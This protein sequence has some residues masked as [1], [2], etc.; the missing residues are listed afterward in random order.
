MSKGGLGATSP[1]VI[2]SNTIADMN[3]SLRDIY[4]EENDIGPLF[5]FYRFRGV[6]LRFLWTVNL[7][8]PTVQDGVMYLVR[9]TST[10]A[11]GGGAVDVRAFLNANARVIPLSK[12]DGS[13]FATFYF[14]VKPVEVNSDSVNT[15]QYQPP[16]KKNDWIQTDNQGMDILHRGVDMM[17]QTNT[18]TTGSLYVW[19][20]YYFT[21]KNAR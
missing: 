6:K 12:L 18:G 1:H 16:G 3:F 17:I 15:A 10:Y 21:T 4:I 11:T 20:T 5:R 14:K 9:N 13:K 7:A 2:S 8:S 19:A